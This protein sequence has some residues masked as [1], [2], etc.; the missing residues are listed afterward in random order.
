MEI[1]SRTLVRNTWI[2]SGVLALAIGS[3]D[4]LVARMKLAQYHETL[5][6]AVIA[7]PRNPAVLF[8]KASESEEQRAVARAK[9]GF[10]NLLFLAGQLLTLSGLVLL[11]LGIVQVRRGSATVFATS[12]R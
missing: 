10:Y 8:P 4:V 6:H 7:Q 11:V 2:M 12:S 3:A 1:S 5:A 9:I